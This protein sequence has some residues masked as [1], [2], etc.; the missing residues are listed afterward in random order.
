[1]TYAGGLFG[2]L[3]D[4]GT[5][6]YGLFLPTCLNGQ[7][8]A[9]LRNEE[10]NF[11]HWINFVPEFWIRKDIRKEIQQEGKNCCTDILD[12]TVSLLCFECAACQDARYLKT[13][14]HQVNSSL[15][16]PVDDI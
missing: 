12:C 14:K 8:Y 7:N 15:K 3:G 2:C 6:V 1:M 5:C 16:N 10:C 11:W 4:C 9:Q 13:H